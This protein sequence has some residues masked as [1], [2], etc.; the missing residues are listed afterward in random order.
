MQNVCAA[1]RFSRSLG[2]VEAQISACCS[3]CVCGFQVS[4]TSFCVPAIFLKSSPEVVNQDTAWCTSN[5]GYCCQA[6]HLQMQ[7]MQQLEGV[8]DHQETCFKEL[9]GSCTTLES[10]NFYNL[11]RVPDPTVFPPPR[12]EAGDNAVECGRYHLII[13]LACPWATK[14]NIM[15]SLKGLEVVLSSCHAIQVAF[16]PRR[17]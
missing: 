14:A 16:A 1:D 7:G 10:Y 12:L 6:I 5:K 15:R 17:A 11:C 3:S 4:S 8:S 2:K 9:L 13:S